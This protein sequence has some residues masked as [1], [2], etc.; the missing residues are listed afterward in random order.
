[1]A[2]NKRALMLA[3]V[4]SMIDQFNIPNIKMLQSLGYTVDVSADFSD[5]GNISVERAQDLRK[6]LESD[7]VAVFDTPIPRALSPKRV[8]EAY[9]QVKQQADNGNY[10]L[11]HCHSPIGGA[12][13]RL[14]FRK[15]RKQGTKVIYTAHGFHFYKGAPFKNW[16]VFYP[17]E[18][19]LSRFTDILITINKEDY[20]RAKDTFHAKETVYVPGIG[21]DTARF[22]DKGGRAKIRKEFGI[23]DD[24]MVFLSVGELNVN[25]NHSTAIKALSRIDREYTYIIVGKGV[26]EEELKEIARETGIG[27]KVIFAGF[28]SDVADFYTAADFFVFPS[29]R[30]GLSVS[31]MEAM[32]SGMSIVC[33]R[34]RGN[35]D[36]VDEGK[37]GYLFDPADAE[38][39][40][41][42]ICK[43]LDADRKEMGEYNTIKVK[44]FDRSIVKSKMTELYL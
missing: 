27:D 18:R 26:L 8:A 21:I 39:V 32:A 42:A 12:L 29:F 2:E 43:A 24:R 16:L 34:I 23:P 41:D 35:T 10:R 9:R 30:E 7:G 28:R 33:S 37:G 13:T 20:K 44:D 38:S 22:A 31:L 15:H 19:V 5:P 25:K 4:A 14:A 3:S 1:M 11:V 40:R 36:L 17:V 6:E